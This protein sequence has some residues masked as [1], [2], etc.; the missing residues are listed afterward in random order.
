[1]PSRPAARTAARRVATSVG[2]VAICLLAVASPAA[3]HTS[4]LSSTPST[5][6][7]LDESPTTAQLRFAAPVDAGLTSA[8]LRRS[9]GSTVAG[10]AVTTPAGSSTTTVDVVLPPLDDGVYGLVWQSV[11]PDG[12]RV[13]GEVVF[14]VGPDPGAA[15]RSAAF[16]SSAPLDRALDV[17][18]VVARAAWY[19]GLALVVGVAVV[20]LAAG[21]RPGPV[22]GWAPGALRLSLRAAAGAALARGALTAAVIAR[23]SGG[24]LGHRVFDAVRTRGTSAWLVA[25][26]ALLGGAAAL[27]RQRAHVSGGQPADP[28]HHRT[29]EVRRTA[30]AALAAAA[31]AVGAGVVAGHAI[32]R[33]SP[34]LAVAVAVGHGAAA[35]VWIG[36]LAA[37]LWLARSS[38]WRAAAAGARREALAAVLRTY[39][40]AAL[41]AFAVLA[42]TGTQQALSALDA[43][44]TSYRVLLAIKAGLVL[45]VLLPL[46]Y[47]HHRA[48]RSVGADAAAG[49]RGPL[50]RTGRLEVAGMAVVVLAGSALVALDPGP[51]APDAALAAPDSA[52]ADLLAGADPTDV[53][54]CV[55]LPVGAPDCYRGYLAGVLDREGTQAAVDELTRL[56]QDDAYVSGNCHQVAHDLGRD[57][58]EKIDGLGE[59]L[60]VEASVCW[61]GYYH[62][63]VEFRMSQ[64]DD[65]ELRTSLPTFCAEPA[66]DRYAFPHYNCLHGLGHGLMLRHDADL[67]AAAP[68]CELFSEHWEARSCMSGLFMENVISAQEGNEPPALRDD[69]LLY[70]C[71]A[72]DE[73]FKEDCYLMQTSYVLWKLG[74]DREAAFTWCDRAEEAYLSTCYRSMGRD[75][76]GGSLLDPATVVRECSL[77]RPDQLEWCIEGAATNAVFDQSGRQAADA[78]CA[79]VDGPVAARCQEAVDTAVATLR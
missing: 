5:R 75:I 17:A 4:L 58:S 2:A 62:G 36:P 56:S 55:D 69:D 25:A 18:S 79:L 28:P 22:A 12:H 24:D 6:S 57:A 15:L 11:G 42:A 27:A 20:A 54:A 68:W 60:A 9:D 67:F 76:S 8:E 71:P 46:G 77:G 40:R 70:P 65:D 66:R 3:A 53:S 39:R 45:V 59:A 10:A 78:L 31:V 63:V 61:S 44:G 50:A 13:S 64:L 73:A 34:A 41:V 32:A 21:A 19:L 16:S 48:T 38:P 29:R 30:A 23:A 47:G 37:M 7:A 49:R 74:G 43:A 51:A 33:P 26:A 72:I 1:M 14:G 52:L 35:A